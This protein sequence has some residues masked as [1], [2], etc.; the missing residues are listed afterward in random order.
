MD[1]Y[2]HV[3]IIDL[4]SNPFRRVEHYPIRREKVEALIESIGRTGFW[5]NL[6]VRPSPTKKGKFERAF[7]EHRAAALNEYFNDP[8][9][10]VGVIVRQ[11]SDEDMIL[12]MARENLEEWGKTSGIVEIETVHS[13]VLA[14]ADGKIKLTPPEV[15]GHYNAKIKG[16]IAPH[17]ETVEISANGGQTNAFVHLYSAKGVAAFLNWPIAKVKD[18]LTA[19]QFIEQGDLKLDVFEGLN[20]SNCAAIISQAR[21]KYI[22]R[23]DAAKAE[24]AQAAQ[25][26]KEAKAAA[27][28]AAEAKDAEEKEAARQALVSAQ[29]K[30]ETHKEV[31]KTYRTRAREAVTKVG[32]GL[33]QALKSG[34][35][36]YKEAADI[37]DEIIHDRPKERELMQAEKFIEKLAG[38]LYEVLRPG[39]D[40]RTEKLDEVIQA[41]RDRSIEIEPRKI[42][43]LALTLVNLSKRAMAYADQL[44]PTGNA[45]KFVSGLNDTRMLEDV[46]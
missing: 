35:R 16:R 18:S 25:A 7:G 4:L 9:H 1:K 27:K 20:T 15:S 34:T 19:L 30:Q 11:I 24:E 5:D 44:A 8:H 32:H 13:V 42:R 17:F 46:K 3:P 41:T 38:N 45:V 33:S 6:L 39:F 37:A 10:K 2:I 43:N 40:S 21:K 36:G 22:D 26:E 28:M 31:A 12:I 29:K 14:F 23:I